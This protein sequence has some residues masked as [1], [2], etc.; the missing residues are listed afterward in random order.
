MSPFFS[1]L[2]INYNGGDYLQNAINSLARQSFSDFET[3]IIDNDS[4][5]GSMEG[6]DV[7]A[8]PACTIECLGRNSGFAEGN[9]I[10][11]KMAKGEW[12]VLLNADAAAE[13]NWLETLRA[14]I[15]DYPDCRMFASTQLFMDDPTI[16]D[17][18]GD[19]YTAWGF[20]WRGGYHHPVTK[21][22]DLG[23]TF[24]PC[25]ASA[26]YER[27][28]FLKH[29]GF[30][31]RYFCFM[32]DVDLA[33]RMRL[34]GE[35]CLFLPEAVVEHKGGGLSGEKSEFSVFHGA[36]NRVWTYLGN[37]PAPL[38]W[39]TLPGHLFLTA[40]LIIWYWNRPYGKHVLNGTKAG[41]ADGL[42]FRRER[43]ATRKGRKVSLIDVAKMV[44]WNPFPMSRHDIA[45]R[46]YTPK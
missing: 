15:T 35:Y 30:D 26:V 1:V 23:E 36:R 8:L 31:E 41:W 33:F 25:G 5:D 37:M 29:G 46:N 7:S 9:N 21:H 42:A 10:A 13:P 16:M 39:L 34:D 24:A 4:R 14:A 40:Y 6:L 12:L 44:H 11:A 32:E 28:T 22:P 3:I 17:G 2:I 27:E 43:K 45:V 19:G 18:A 20:A 38:L